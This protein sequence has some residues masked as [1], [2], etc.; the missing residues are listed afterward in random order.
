MKVFI[1]KSRVA[2]YKYDEFELDIIA[3]QLGE[4]TIIFENCSGKTDSRRVTAD[5]E[6]I[7]IAIRNFII[8]FPPTGSRKIP[9]GYWFK[10]KITEREVN[11][12]RYMRENG[13]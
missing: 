6:S 9:D 11:Q 4:I 2:H 10:C 8:D 5:E 13:Q 3:R 7:L 12:Q 1:T